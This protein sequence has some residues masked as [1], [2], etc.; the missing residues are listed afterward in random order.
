MRTANVLLAGIGAGGIVGILVAQFGTSTLASPDLYVVAVQRANERYGS[1]LGPLFDRFG[2]Y[3]VFTTGWFS[4]LVLA[5]ATAA[6]ANTLIRAPR[7]VRDIRNVPTRRGRAYFRSGLPGRSGPVEGLDGNPLPGLLSAAHYRV[8]TEEVAGITHLFAEKNRFA[9]LGSLLSHGALPIFV[10]A[11]GFVTPRFGYETALKVPVG[12]ERPTLAPGDPENLMVKNEAFVAQFDAR[13]R[14]LAYRATL[15]VYRAGDLLTRKEILVNDPLSVEGFVFHENFFGP[16]VEVEVRDADGL[17]FGGSVLLDGQLDGKPE[18]ALAIPGSDV[19]LELL[20]EKGSGG[21]AKLTVIGVR[22]AATP[23][24]PPMILFGDVL[25][26]GDQ[27][28]PVG[29]PMAISFIRPSSYIGLIAKRDPGQGLIWLGAVLLVAGLTVS[30]GRPRRRIWARYDGRSVRLAVIGGDP[31]VQA[32][33]ES[34]LSRLPQ[35]AAVL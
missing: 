33:L 9:P 28:L 10:V 5:F 13:G 21:V 19:S 29:Q 35:S 34:L 6:T 12:E 23:G 17:L 20:L 7:I 11:M 15:A 27:L 14:P 16:A 1:I 3:H 32:E 24:D 4:L 26:T 2:F 8:R 30:L 25:E 31:F 18:G 22:P